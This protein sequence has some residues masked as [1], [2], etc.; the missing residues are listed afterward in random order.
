MGVFRAMAGWDEVER[1]ARAADAAVPDGAMGSAWLWGILHAEV[2]VENAGKVVRAV[3]E[4]LPSKPI[5]FTIKGVQGGEVSAENIRPE[6]FDETLAKL[7][8]AAKEL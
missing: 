3:Q 7:V 6:D 2:T 8:A 4:R 1:V 5:K